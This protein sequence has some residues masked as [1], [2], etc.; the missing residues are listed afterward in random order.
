MALDSI[1][2]K[3][4]LAPEIEAQMRIFLSLGST[5]Y[6]QMTNFANSMATAIASKVVAE[7]TANAQLNGANCPGGT[8]TVN[9]SNQVVV[10]N[11]TVTGGV[12]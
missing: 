10:P 8:Y 9:V 5:P 4:A 2:L 1:R 6:P 3:N 7:I 12:I 11:K